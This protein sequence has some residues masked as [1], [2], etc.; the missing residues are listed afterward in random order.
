[1]KRVYIVLYHQFRCLPFFVSK[2]PEILLVEISIEIVFGRDF[3]LDVF[4]G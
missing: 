1:M 3:F 4:F 2:K